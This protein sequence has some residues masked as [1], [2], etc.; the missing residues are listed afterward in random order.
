MR[1]TWDVP[2]FLKWCTVRASRRFVTPA[3]TER[4]PFARRSKSR[5]RAS[6]RGCSTLRKQPGLQ[7]TIGF[8]GLI[9]LL[10]AG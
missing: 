5:S 7:Q 2:D 4:C 3:G 8:A 9:G 10:R 6:S 1:A